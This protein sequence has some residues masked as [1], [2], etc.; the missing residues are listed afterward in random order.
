MIALVDYGL[1]NIHAFANIYKSLN[2]PV[3]VADTAE[4]LD[5]ADHIIL[6]G[7]G[8]FDWAMAKLNDSGMRILLDEMVLLRKIPVLGVCVGMQMMARRSDE[9]KMPGLGWIGGEVKK[10]DDAAFVQQTHLPHMGWNNVLPQKTGGLFADMADNPLFYFLHSYYFS[11]A[12]AE[13][14]LALTDYNGMFASAVA[15][16]NVFGM[17]FHPEKSH[18]AG[19]QLLKNFAGL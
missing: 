17:Q 2:I 13:E 11:P 10:F 19:I 4:K 9:G 6:P 16:D 8:A 1:G 5:D 14:C 12:S 15:C 3:V 18:R 7:V